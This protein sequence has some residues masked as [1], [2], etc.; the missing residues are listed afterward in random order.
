M[1]MLLLFGDDV[2]N[3]VIAS[4][5]GYLVPFMLVIPAFVL[6]R[7][8]KPAMLRPFRLPDTFVPIA[9]VITAFNWLIFFVGGLQWGLKEMMTGVAVVLTFL[10]FYLVR[11]LSQ[12]R[13]SGVNR[14]ASPESLSLGAPE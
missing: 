3:Q 10:P 2:V 7:R 5:F 13:R 12:D 11:R 8:R 1:G 4:N 14:V 6:L 9:V